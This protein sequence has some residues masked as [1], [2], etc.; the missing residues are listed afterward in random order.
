M[1]EL[2][3]RARLVGAGFSA[4]EIDY[5]MTLQERDVLVLHLERER[6]EDHQRTTSAMVTAVAS[7]FS[8]DAAKQMGDAVQDSSDK[9][10]DLI[11]ERLGVSEEDLEAEQVEQ[12][13]EAQPGPNRKQVL[14]DVQKLDNIM[15]QLT[16]AMVINPYSASRMGSVHLGS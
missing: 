11:H 6:L 14:R 8:A 7:A 3:V 12:E 2:Q 1:T 9:I 15:S 16:G 5:D 10:S 4:A 13:Q